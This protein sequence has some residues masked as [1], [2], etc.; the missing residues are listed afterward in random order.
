MQDENS[1]IKQK[2]FTAVKNGN[3]SE[4]T[5]FFRNYDIKPW[6]FKEED[7]YTGKYKNYYIFN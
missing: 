7:E 2:F 6:L 4:M 5:K 3:A 1:E